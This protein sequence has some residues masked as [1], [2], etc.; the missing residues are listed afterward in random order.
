MKSASENIKNDLTEVGYQD[1]RWMEQ[2]K[3]HIQRQLLKL[4]VLKPWVL[5]TQ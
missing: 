2:A 1:G 5:L 3:D 4:I